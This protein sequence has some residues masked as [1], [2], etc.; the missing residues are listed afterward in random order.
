MNKLELQKTLELLQA[1]GSQNEKNPADL[2]NKVIVE[3]DKL[4]NNFNNSFIT[5]VE[6]EFGFEG[7][8]DL[9]TFVKVVKSLNSDDI[10]LEYDGVDSYRDP[11]ERKWN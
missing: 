5:V 7:I 10:E 11:R 8:F 1:V 9:T 3:K 2:S 4:I 6:Q